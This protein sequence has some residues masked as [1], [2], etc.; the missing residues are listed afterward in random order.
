MYVIHPSILAFSGLWSLENKLTIKKH[1]SPTCL[2]SQTQSSSIHSN[3]PIK[4]T[5]QAQSWGI[6]EM[7]TRNP[8]CLRVLQHT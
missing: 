1:P 8:N 4:R 5:S 6:A 7:M 3:W 2:S